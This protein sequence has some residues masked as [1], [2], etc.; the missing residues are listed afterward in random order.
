MIQANLIT[1][2]NIRFRKRFSIVSE[3][4][5]DLSSWVSVPDL[6]IYAKRPL[7]VKNDVVTM[8]EPPLCAVEIISS[9]QSLNDLVAKARAY[10]A[11]GVRS[12]WIVIPA[13]ENIYVFSSAD[14]YRIYRSSEELSDS[15]LDLAFPLKAVFE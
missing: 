13:L 11:H 9:T 12:C 6:A 8:T 3:L 2:L 15:V 4:S 5:L 1:E 10:F 7:D 14:D